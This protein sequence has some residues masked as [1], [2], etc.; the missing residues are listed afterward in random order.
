MTKKSIKLLYVALYFPPLGG[1]ASLRA[2]KHVKYLARMGYQIS[3]LTILPGFVRYPR[4]HELLKDIPAGVKIYRSFFPDPEWLFKLL[5][6]LRLPK[7][8]SFLR[9]RLFSPDTASLWLPF[10][11][12]R[13]KRILKQELHFNLALITSGPPSSLLLGP[14]LKKRFGIPY[15]CDFR[16]EWTN[17]PERMNISYPENSQAQEVRMESS[18]I[19]ACSGAAFLTTIMRENFESSYPILKNLPSTILTNGFD[20]DDFL[21]RKPIRKAQNFHLVYCGSFYDRRQ[22]DALWKAI[23]ELINN[24]MIPRNKVCVDIYGKNS[25]AFVLGTFAN[26]PLIRSI[27]RLH[28][29][30]SH[31][32]SLEIMLGSDALLLYI[33]SGK[34]TDSVLTGKIFEYIRC[35][36]PILAIVPPAGIAAEIVTKAGLGFIADHSDDEGIKDRIMQLW[37]LWQTDTLKEIKPDADYIS[38][39]SRQKLA[40]KLDI[41]IREVLG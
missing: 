20:D 16:D 31:R 34:N 1:V 25:P 38:G 28:G 36:K 23:S 17:N 10:A 24:G 13:L 30:V 32:K 3:V 7:L 6:G 18:V 19:N 33:P 27:V 5:Y 26:D 37:H 14:W 29:F 2:V 35:A 12:M 4:D 15:I 21:Y 40:Q 22:P 9:F 11:K 8:V 39:Y 41:L